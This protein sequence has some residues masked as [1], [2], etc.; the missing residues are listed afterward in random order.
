MSNEKSI[1]DTV[2]VNASNGKGAKTQTIIKRSIVI[3]GHKTSISLED[4]FWDQLKDIAHARHSNLSQLVAQIDQ[5]RTGNLSS[6]IRVF[7]LENLRD[8]VR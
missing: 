5:T 6:A 7:I 4:S 2:S 1:R 3:G 8:R